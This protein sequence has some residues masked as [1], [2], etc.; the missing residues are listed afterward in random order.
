LALGGLYLR[1]RR[2]VE[3]LLLAG[4]AYA[5][6]ISVRHST[7]FVILA[8]PMIATELSY[9]WQAWVARQ[10]RA[11]AARILDGL[12]SEK[13][14]AFSRNSVWLLAGLATIFVWTPRDMWPSGF[15]AKMFPVEL[16]SRHPELATARMFTPDQWA[17]YLL[18]AN[19]PR[20]KVFYDDRAF[21]GEK[22]YRSVNGLLTAQSGWAATLEAYGIDRVLIQTGS[23]LSARLRESSSWSVI[24]QD[25][26][27]E[28]F[29]RRNANGSIPESPSHAESAR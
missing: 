6:L 7:V 9:Y 27:A 20:Q 28:L 22:L 21:Y 16:A 25:S 11:S 3:P 29:T 13:R 1:R 19:Y 5:A 26:T 10:P 23:P 2:F 17:D 12:S 18:Y 14:A 8:A 4:T 24:D 15:D